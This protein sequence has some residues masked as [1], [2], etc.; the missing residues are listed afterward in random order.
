MVPVRGKPIRRNAGSLNELTV[1]KSDGCGA[2][3]RVGWDRLDPHVNNHEKMTIMA[4]QPSLLDELRTQ[5]EA[6]RQAVPPPPDVEDFQHIDAR[7]RKA[8]RWLEKAISYLDE[9]SLPSI[10]ASIWAM[11]SCSNRPGSGAARWGNTSAAS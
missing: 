9:L 3:N 6:A 1:R 11:D 4:N 8:F 10:I 2:A 7:M 5:Y